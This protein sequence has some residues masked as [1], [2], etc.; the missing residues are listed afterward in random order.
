M[1]AFRTAVRSFLQKR[2][3]VETSLLHQ[4]VDPAILRG[5]KPFY[6]R[7]LP[8]WSRYTYTL[9]C[10]NVIVTFVL[11]LTYFLLSWSDIVLL[12][13]S[14]LSSAGCSVEY[15]SALC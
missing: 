4:G 3:S 2:A 1:Q 8:L 5:L 15:L 11:V 12:S 9:V 7:K 10:I 6:E 13:M 14:T